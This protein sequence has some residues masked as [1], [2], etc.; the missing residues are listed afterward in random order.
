MDRRSVA[1]NRSMSADLDA[2]ASGGSVDVI[3]VGEYDEPVEMG[4]LR[5]SS[6]MAHEELDDIHSVEISP[7]IRQHRQALAA[8]L[9]SAGFVNHPGQ[10]WHWSFGDAY[11]AAAT[12][13]PSAIFEAVNYVPSV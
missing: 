3:L 4:Q 11:W 1:W 8:A 12:H 6:E 7:E 13:V 2:Y 5:H 10:W 9:A